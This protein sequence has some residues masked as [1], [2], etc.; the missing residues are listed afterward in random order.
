MTRVAAIAGILV[1]S[2]TPAYA[3]D[4]SRARGAMP[5]DIV[6][7]ARQIQQ[8]YPAAALRNAEQGIV[9][10]RIVIGSDGRVRSCEVTQTSESEAL[11]QAACRG[12]VDY[13]RY[14]PARDHSGKPIADST[15]QSVRYILPDGDGMARSFMPP[16]PIEMDRWRE[17]A[18]DAEFETRM[19]ESGNGT[20]LYA[21]TID[22]EGNVSGCGVMQS[23]GSSE[24]D[25][26]VC[27]S[28][29][30][31]AEFHPSWVHKESVNG[32]FAVPYP[33]YEALRTV[34]S[35]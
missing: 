20:A 25:N 26:G 19:R 31:N 21:L 17:L 14:E 8:D 4:E 32:F 23:S 33:S 5:K 27:R 34:R 9:I 24:L 29:F 18:F 35:Q 10:M 7:W 28:L 1:A 13:A 6:A 3:Q 16:L 12:M 2:L 11:D 30:K 15:T 22:P